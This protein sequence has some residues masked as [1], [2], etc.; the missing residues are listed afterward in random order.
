MKR[1][2]FLFLLVF[3]ISIAL[4]GCAGEEAVEVDTESAEEDEVANEVF[5][6]EGWSSAFY[7]PE[8]M[9]G[10]VLNMYC[11]TDAVEPI[12]RDFQDDTGIRIDHLTMENAEM[13]SRL[14][15]EYEANNVI[16]DLWFTGGADTFITGAREGLTIPYLSP[17]GEDIG[18]NKKDKA[19]YWYGTSLT[20]V[21]WVVNED[22][23]EEM[24]IDMPG[25]WDDLLQEELTGEVSMP[26]PS[27]SGTSYNVI[28][29][30]IQ[31]RGEQ[32]GWEY[33]EKLNQQ[34]PFY[35]SRGSDPKQ[36]VI[37][38][39]AIVGINPSSG[40]LLLEEEYP[41]IKL[42]FPEDGTGWWPQPVSIVNGTDKEEAAKVFI[43]WILS[44]KGMQSVAEH[45]YAAVV[46]PGVETPEGI[47]EIDDI[48]LFETD[49]EANAED[50]EEILEKW[51]ELLRN[52]E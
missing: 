16:A 18:D 44:R 51:E 13:L 27:T 36:N 8:E 3:V 14:R 2:T 19:G 20:L 4:L 32:E 33:L 5:E 35:T 21:N 26:D 6:G 1:L 24:G 12:L 30:I 29:A 49:F 17:H 41:H 46:K 25:N 11:V 31:L 37:N 34:V 28:S 45:R 15:N 43:D 9:E 10:M 40:D 7:D 23:V 47:I 22:L 50:R 39:E 42:V 48:E 52:A 38:G